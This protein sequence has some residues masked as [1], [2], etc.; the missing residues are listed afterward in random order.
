MKT[1]FHDYSSWE[2]YRKGF[3]DWSG[4]LTVEV[5]P[6][7][8]RNDAVLTEQLFNQFETVC[9]FYLGHLRTGDITLT[10]KDM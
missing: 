10:R 6:S 5:S 1:T 3:D 9:S 4:I 2:S 7:G 8:F